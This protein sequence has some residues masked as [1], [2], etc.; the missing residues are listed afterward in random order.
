MVKLF[1]NKVN[2]NDDIDWAEAACRSSLIDE[3]TD[4]F[5]DTKDEQ[6]AIRICSSCPVMTSCGQFAIDNKIEFGVWGGLS[7]KTR[8]LATARKVRVHCPS[9]RGIDI[10]NDGSNRQC[11]L[12]CGLSWN[13]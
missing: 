12:K 8:R 2:A 13:I 4:V 3:V 1:K 10:F 11:C 7:E 6:L 5:F 9:C